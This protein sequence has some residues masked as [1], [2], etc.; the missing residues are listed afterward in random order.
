MTASPLKFPGG[1]AP[2]AQRILA[3]FPPKRSEQYPDGYLSF[4][5]PFAGG[6][7]VLLAHDPENCS[8]VANDKNEILMNFW[9]CLRDDQFF[10]AFK[11]SMDCT[12][13]SQGLWDESLAVLK[14]AEK[15]SCF[16]GDKNKRFGMALAFF[17][18]CR[19]S[20]AGRMKSFAPLSKTRLRRGMNEQASA[21]LTCVEGLPEVHERLR[22]VVLLN[23]DA[24]KVIDAE[25]DPGMLTLCDPPYV[26][27]TRTAQDVYQHE[28]SLEDHERLLTLLAGIQGRF[29]LCGYDNPLY[30]RFAEKH[31]WERHV[32]DVP[33][34]AAGGKEKRRMSE[35]IL[36]NFRQDGT[37]IS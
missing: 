16:K 19:Q 31:G 14:H 1:K 18:C 34:N 32:F 8:E 5:E 35:M 37:R 26:Q 3:L 23:D 4:V 28:M 6:L 12:P 15:C 21:W 24:L 9:V 13:F 22:R 11:K 17:V 33:N 29:L 10:E 20:L 2:L 7:S 36:R 30:A 27:S 25:D